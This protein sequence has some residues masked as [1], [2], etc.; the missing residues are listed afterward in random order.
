MRGL[1]STD[2]E[3]PRFPNILFGVSC[4]LV[5]VVVRRRGLVGVGGVVGRTCSS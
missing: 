4:C 5:C 3:V 1:G 2:G